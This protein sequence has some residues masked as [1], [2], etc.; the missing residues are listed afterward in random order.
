M[1]AELRFLRGLEAQL[2]TSA[3]DGAFYLTTDTHRLFV[4]QGE[5]LVAVNEGVITVA[6]IA[7]LPETAIPGS[8]YYATA[9]NILC[10][11][12][13]QNFI[14]INSDTGMTSVEVAGEGNA[15]TAAS[16]DAATRKLTL[17]RGETFATKAELDEAVGGLE[18]D[19]G[20]AQAAAEAAQSAVDALD[21]KVGVV[22]EGSDTV[23]AY[24]NKKAQEVLDSA[25]GGSSESAASVKLA[26]DNYMAEN[27]PKVA[28]NTKGVADNTAAIEAEVIR[29]TGVEA[30]LEGRI[31]TMEA[32]WEAAQ[33]DG[34]DSN[35]IDTLKEIQEYIV[36]DETGAAAMAASIKQNSDAIATLDNEVGNAAVAGSGVEGEEGYVAPVAATG[37]YKKIEDGDAATLQS[38]N[39]YA[40]AAV[41][42]LNIGNYATVESVNTLDAKVGTL[43][44]GFTSVVGYVDS[45]MAA[46]DGDMSALTGRVSTLETDMV[47]V[48]SGLEA[49]DGKISAAVSAHEAAHHT[50]GTFGQ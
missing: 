17:T 6:S 25:T 14:Q 19:I 33:A 50:W 27:D 31:E 1:N 38:A 24:I 32:F 36:S 4:G 3:Q 41:A 13:G 40:D 8:F 21:A 23:I 2:P 47:D 48:K 42:A 30:G 28:A 5:E 15:V 9:E 43:P 18:T 26:L 44:E 45:K 16:Y 35:V 39:A 10:V 22:P 20:T 49:V 37:L 12:N 46:V 29:A 11:H 34:T 7:A